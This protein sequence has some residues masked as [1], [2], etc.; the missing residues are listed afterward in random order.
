MTF[1]DTEIP[2]VVLVDPDVVQDERGA[3]VVVWHDGCG[4]DLSAYGIFGRRYSSAGGAIGD[5]FQVNTF[6]SGIQSYP[7]VAM[8]GN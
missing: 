4:K 1:N 8:E 6:T 5:E 2:G 3:F 7:S